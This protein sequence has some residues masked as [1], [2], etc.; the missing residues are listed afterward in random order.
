MFLFVTPRQQPGEEAWFG[1]HKTM[2][3]HWKWKTSRTPITFHP[4]D[5]R[6]VQKDDCVFLKDSGQWQG[7]RGLGCLDKKH[8]LC[9]SEIDINATSSTNVS[10]T[11][12]DLVMSSSQFSTTTSIKPPLTSSPCPSLAGTTNNN[13]YTNTGNNSYIDTET[14]PP[15]VPSPLANQHT[16]T[17]PKAVSM[18]TDKHTSTRGGPSLPDEHG[19]EPV[20]KPSTEHRVST[21]GNLDNDNE[22]GDMWHALYDKHVWSCRNCGSRSRRRYTRP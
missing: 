8:S 20:T 22:A 19:D 7:R 12:Q 15:P 3:G 13:L 9:E 18:T 17:N 10:T 5:A 4:M 11:D 16:V 6:V 21:S 1:L 14:S 2:L